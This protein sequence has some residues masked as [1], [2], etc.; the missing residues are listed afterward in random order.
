MDSYKEAF[1]ATKKHKVHRENDT[2]DDI[3]KCLGQGKIQVLWIKDRGIGLGTEQMNELLKAG[4]SQKQHKR[5]SYGLGHLTAFP[6]STLR[7]VVYGG[8]TEKEQILSGQC[9]LASH[10]INK[11]K[12]GPKGSI[13]WNEQQENLFRQ[14]VPQGFRS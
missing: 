5:G 10:V 6:A 3:T 8:C 13:C 11:E 9:I 2:I 12:R 14:G 4:K 1:E 7:Y